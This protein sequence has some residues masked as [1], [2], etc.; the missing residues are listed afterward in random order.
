MWFSAC[1]RDLCAILEKLLEEVDLRLRLWGCI[2]SYVS[3]YRS[4]LYAAT[5]AESLQQA[6][7]SATT[8][9]TFVGRF[10]KTST[11]KVHSFGVIVIIFSA[12]VIGSGTGQ[13]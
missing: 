5:K 13:G 8:S 7:T 6:S 2:G 9:G 4:L 10:R 3:E 11:I 12:S 1:P